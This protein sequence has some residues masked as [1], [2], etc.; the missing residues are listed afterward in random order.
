MTVS[1][2]LI[3]V[4]VI[5]G[6]WNIILSGWGW[7]GVYG[8][9]FWMGVG[10]VGHYFGWVGVGGKI[11]WVDGGGWGWMGMSGVGGDEWWWVHCLMFDNADK[12]VNTIFEWKSL[13]SRLIFTHTVSCSSLSH[14]IV[15]KYNT[16]L[17]PE[18]ERMTCLTNYR[19][20]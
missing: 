5:L 16:R 18:T 4:S 6:G 20:I 3:W 10:C 9:L 15:E 14:K 1:E 19:T 17:S 11:F 8:A 7:V 13:L 12:S 2:A